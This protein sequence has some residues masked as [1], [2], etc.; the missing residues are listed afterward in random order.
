MSKPDK[1]PVSLQNLHTNTELIRLFIILTLVLSAA[2][3]GF[4]D[5]DALPPKGKIKGA[6]IDAK[7]KEPLEYA[8]VALYNAK[9][10][11]L[12]TGTITDFSG[13]FKIDRPQSGAYYL[14]ITF[15]GLKDLKNR[16]V[17]H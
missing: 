17:Q 14:S 4:A 5:G 10:N 9:T 3:Q 1:K 12:I 2:H 6:V 13:H 15:V 7:S 8:T 16:C 11:E